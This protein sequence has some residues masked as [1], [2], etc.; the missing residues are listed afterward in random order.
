[1]TTMDEDVSA[2]TNAIEIIGC[3]QVQVACLGV[4]ASPRVLNRGSALR[5]RVVRAASFVI[6]PH[7]IGIKSTN[8][9]RRNSNTYERAPLRDLHHVET[10]HNDCRRSI[11]LP[12]RIVRRIR[13]HTS[14]VFIIII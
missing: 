5:V 13:I 8:K 2:E 9:H 7:C 6:L 3:N 10:L 12:R 1:M 11:I 14:S 4:R